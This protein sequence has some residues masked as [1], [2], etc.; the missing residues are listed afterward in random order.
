MWA[1]RMRSPADR[2]ARAGVR[3][4]G[5]G[6]SGPSPLPPSPPRVWLSCPL[7]PPSP[8]APTRTR[9]QGAG[10]APTA[11]AATRRR[12]GRFPGGW[13]GATARSCGASSPRRWGGVR[14]GG[15]RREG[16]GCQGG[17]E[18]GEGAGGAGGWQE[19]YRGDCKA[20]RWTRLSSTPCPSATPARQL[21]AELR[22]RRA[23]FPKLRIS[24]LRTAAE[25]GPQRPQ[26]GRLRVAHQHGGSLRVYQIYRRVRRRHHDAAVAS[27]MLRRAAENYESL[28][29]AR[30]CKICG[31]WM[32]STDLIERFWCGL[33]NRSADK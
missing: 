32:S 8:R 12:R 17:R 24:R 1:G 33:V 30:K 18:G 19:G 11:A 4:A 5:P 27:S 6:P 25:C 7:P 20:R 9:A 3:H 2:R 16:M 29:F 21:L 14:V 26:R 15:G 31:Q 22:G 28:R 13:G 23:R 10:A